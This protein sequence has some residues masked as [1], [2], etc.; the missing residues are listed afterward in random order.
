MKEMGLPR[1]DLMPEMELTGMRSKY[2]CKAVAESISG[3]L[4]DWFDSGCAIFL[5][6]LRLLL[7]LLL[8]VSSCCSPDL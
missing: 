5:I 7:L 4:W 8:L 3:V 2:C 1:A 6:Q